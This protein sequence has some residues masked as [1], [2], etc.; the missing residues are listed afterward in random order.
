MNS[1]VGWLKKGPVKAKSY[2]NS[3]YSF[4]QT[5]VLRTHQMLYLP[6]FNL[7]SLNNMERESYAHNWIIKIFFYSYCFGTLEVMMLELDHLF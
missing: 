7:N 3:I 4:I 1:N 6:I 5:Y 2:I